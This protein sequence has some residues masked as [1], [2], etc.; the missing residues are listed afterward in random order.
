MKNETATLSIEVNRKIKEKYVQGFRNL[1]DA[2]QNLASQPVEELMV[3]KGLHY[4]K[5]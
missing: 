4:R 3:N 2:A 1:S 5:N